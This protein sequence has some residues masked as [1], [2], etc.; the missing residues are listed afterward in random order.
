RSPA[1]GWWWSSSVSPRP[2]PGP[3]RRSG[4]EYEQPPPA[5]L[6]QHDTGQR[7]PDRRCPA[8][9]AVTRAI[10]WP[11]RAAG[12]RRIAVVISNG[13]NTA[14]PTAWTVRP[15]NRTSKP[16]ASADRRAERE[17]RHR[18]QKVHAQVEPAHHRGP[19]I[20]ERPRSTVVNSTGT[21]AIASCIGVPWVVPEGPLAL[22]ASD[23]ARHSC[24]SSEAAARVAPGK[25]F[26]A[27]MT[28]SGSEAAGGPADDERG[29]DDRLA[30]GFAVQS[31]ERLFHGCCG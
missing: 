26:R 23:V 1:P 10:V 25:S 29:R 7:G 9:T 8:G 14:V 28:L 3:P 21:L 12:T 20:H 22:G 4:A 17:Q 19:T 5:P 16:G 30:T 6:G 31:I 13:R 2:G 27:V 15:A 11:R 24:G 18:I